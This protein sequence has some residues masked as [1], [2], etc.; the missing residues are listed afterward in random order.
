MKHVLIVDDAL[1]LGRLLQT[2][3]TSLEAQL[4][5][6]V[7]PSAEEA[8]LEA[9]RSKIDLLV[10]DVRLPGMSGMELVRKIRV[11][12]PAMKV[13]MITGLTEARVEKEAQEV[14]A[15]YFLRKPLKISVFLEN[16]QECLGLEVT[17]TAAN[18]AVSASNKNLD[19]PVSE[20]TRKSQPLHS[21]E[22]KYPEATANTFKKEAAPAAEEP[23]KKTAPMAPGVIEKHNTGGITSALLERLRSA[24]DAQAVFLLEDRGLVLAR[25]GNLP[26][27]QVENQLI[28][29][30]LAVMGASGL[31]SHLLSQRETNFVQFFHG[32]YFD[33]V[34][35]PE[36][37]NILVVALK[38]GQSP[39]RL[40]L[41]LEEMQTLQVSH[42]LSQQVQGKPQV[43]FAP[44]TQTQV[45][46]IEEKQSSK[47]VKA[48]QPEEVSMGEKIMLDKLEKLVGKE[49]ETGKKEEAESFWADSLDDDQM[50]PTG[51]DL[52]SFDQAS[53]LGLTP[54]DLENKTK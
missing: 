36:D 48:K 39:L 16:A 11:R 5:V 41:T 20:H 7:V 15:D 30:I 54:P 17:K 52:I 46:G 6:A 18:Y 19:K 34:I 31:V 21:E 44:S 23:R 27:S 37:R 43:E 2:A 12:H 9:S 13:I 26:N 38:P 50:K 35:K 32:D 24:L 47:P 14:G 8:L 29:S 45:E 40:A 51:P 25:A 3:L 53:Q 22:E 4:A 49:V 10:S 1:E 42:T 28:P 33:L